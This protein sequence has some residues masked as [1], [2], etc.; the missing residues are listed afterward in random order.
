MDTVF[1]ILT[2]AGLG[3]AA[4]IRPFLPALVAGAAASADLLIDFDGTD[5][6]FLEATGWLL[7][8]IVAL[9]AVVLLQRRLTGEGL[10]RSPAGAAVAGLAL[11]VG[12]LLFAGALADHSGTWWPGVAGGLLCALLAQLAVRDLLR[13]TRARLDPD[14]REA[15]TVYADGA[16]LLLAILAIVAP[17]VSVLA[18][19]VLAWLLVSGRRRAGEKFAGLRILR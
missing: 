12:A 19:A 5:L 2:G 11:G 15:L 16:S 18:L 8:V 1:D 10:D 9:I 4:G 7:A 17:P 6:S 14:A 3:A 13:R